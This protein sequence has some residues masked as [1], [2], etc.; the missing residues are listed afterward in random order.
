MLKFP[1]MLCLESHSAPLFLLL[2]SESLVIGLHLWHF[3]VLAYCVYPER[4][5]LLHSQPSEGEEL[6][7]NAGLALETLA[8]SGERTHT[9]EGC[10]GTAKVVWYGSAQVVV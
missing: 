5:Y 7:Q 1:N 6:Q 4:G 9:R 10:R 8:L 3:L 2:V